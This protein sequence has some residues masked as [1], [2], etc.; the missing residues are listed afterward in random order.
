LKNEK[1]GNR[2]RKTRIEELEKQIIE[3]GANPRYEASILALIN[4]KDREIQVLKRK[5]NILG[6]EH[7]QTP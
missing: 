5:L 4:T 7:A 1:L 6:I 2:S 3:L